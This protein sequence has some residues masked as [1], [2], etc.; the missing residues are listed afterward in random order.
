[1][2]AS[3]LYNDLNSNRSLRLQTLVRLRW[4]AVGGQLLAVIVTALWLQFPLPIVPCSVLIACLALVNVILTLRF[5]P[6]QRL[7]PPAAFALLGLDLAQLTALLFITGGLANPFAP[8]LCVP[9]IISSASQPKPHS[10]V[11]AVFAVVGVT[12]LAFS[13]F[14]LPWYPGTVLLIPHVLTAGIWFAIVSMTAFAAFYT[15]RVSLE[16]SELSEALTATELVL[17]REKH[18]SQLDGLAAAA[19]HELG[20]PLATISVVAKEMERELGDDPRFGE[21]VHLLRSQSERCR[22]ILRRLTTLSSESEEHMR[23]LPLS[24]LIEEVMAPHR[25]FGIEIELKEQG[26]RATEPVGIRNAGILY[27]LGNL[28]EN[29][30]DYA[31]KKVTVTTEHTPERVRV[32][33]EDDGEGFSPD[34]L[35]RIGEPYVTR[36]QK[37]DS[38]GGLGLGLFIAKT[39]LER[40]GA[41]LRF[42]NGGAKHPGARVSVEWPRALMDSKLAK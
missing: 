28:L 15:Y 20:T 10:I 22:D 29:A 18:L 39:L 23:L 34:I 42:E 35:A 38:A 31:R 12:A 37:D 14:Q 26:E 5:P 17:Q 33:I 11:L 7:T 19:A 16:A 13:P 21:D 40:S 4:L 3:T 36:R 1:M 25:E 30:V 32:T 8:L 24:S 6:T 9:V 27:G 41:R 2:A